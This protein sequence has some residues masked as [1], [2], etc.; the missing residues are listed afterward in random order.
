MLVEETR[1]S[2][3]LVSDTLSSLSYICHI[4]LH[5]QAC[6]NGTGGMDLKLE[7]VF[8]SLGLY[9]PSIICFISPLAMLLDTSSQ[10]QTWKTSY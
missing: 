8:S 2:D 5:P 10:I 7:D 6:S 3:V 9:L 1:L 4:E